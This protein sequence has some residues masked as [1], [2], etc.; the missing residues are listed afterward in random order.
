MPDERDTTFSPASAQM[1]RL[2][3][4]N[5][6]GRLAAGQRRLLLLV[7]LIALVALLCPLALLF[8][9]GALMFAEGLRAVASVSGVLFLVFGVL[10]VIIFL[11]LIGTN[12]QLFLA[13]A[14][15][16]RPVR[17]ARGPLEIHMSASER[18]E[19]PF[20]YIVDGYSFAPYIP[21]ADI[22]MQPGATYLVYYAA[23]SRLFLS[24][25]ALDAPDADDWLPAFEQD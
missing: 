10:V 22:P 25:I 2:L 21:P 24:M 6:T 17:Y 8:Q 3:S 15:S 5:R 11:G 4:A 23:H 14:L 7:G 20:S 9:I 18:P 12:A 13:D 1:A 19:L 16:R